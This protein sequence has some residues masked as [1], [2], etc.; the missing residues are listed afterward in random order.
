MNKRTYLVVNTLHFE[1][2]SYYTNGENTFT[3]K[4]EAIKDAKLNI[5]QF[6]AT[7]WFMFE[8]GGVMKKVVRVSSRVEDEKGSEI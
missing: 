7:G 3:V 4:A 8:D 1:D 6:E 5:E 2:G